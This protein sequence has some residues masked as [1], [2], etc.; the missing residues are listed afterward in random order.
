ML[1][2]GPESTASEREQLESYSSLDRCG[3]RRLGSVSVIAFACADVKFG[4][5]RSGGSDLDLVEA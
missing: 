3:L 2:K 1:R 5:M 4:M